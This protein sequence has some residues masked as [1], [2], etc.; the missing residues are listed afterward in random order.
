[1]YDQDEISP[2]RRILWVIGTFIII[3]SVLWGIVWLLFLRHSTPVSKPEQSKNKSSTQSKQ[4]KQSSG[5]SSSSGGGNSSSTGSSS[6]SGAAN[7]PTQPTE[8]ANTGAG[9]VVS[10]FAGVTIVSG[11]AYQIRLRKKLLA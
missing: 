2:L 1:M 7:T 6:S 3:F 4:Q 8:L 5:S 9:D 10:L 11:A